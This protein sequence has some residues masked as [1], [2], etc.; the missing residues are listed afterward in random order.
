MQQALA[1]QVSL[2]HAPPFHR[3]SRP[4]PAPNRWHNAHLPQAFTGVPVAAT[5]RT[6]TGAAALAPAASR[7]QRRLARQATAS[8]TSQQVRWQHATT[9]FIFAAG[10]RPPEVFASAGSAVG[11]PLV[12]MHRCLPLLWCAHSLSCSGKHPLQV[13]AA[14][15]VEAPPAAASTVD[16][17]G[18][19]AE[20]DSKSP[21]EIMDHVGDCCG[22][23]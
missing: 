8:A 18:A 16:W 19:A 15:A 11:R 1:S 9:S 14:A 7:Q 22:C 6:Q 13:N 10:S 20:L 2:G 12:C 17:A 4:T 3:L 23:G 21:L 5:R